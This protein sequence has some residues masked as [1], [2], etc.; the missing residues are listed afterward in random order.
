MGQ[1][2]F[3]F[4]YIYIAIPTTLLFLF[5]SEQS[6]ARGYEVDILRETFKY[7][8]QSKR[9]V[10]LQDIHQGCAKVNCI[11]SIDSPEFARV[12]EYNE[13]RN[14]DIMFV[15]T[16]RGETKIY[17]KQI[18]Q[19]H[20]VVNDKFNGE[21]VVMTYC[22]LCGSVVAFIPKIE[23]QYTHLGVSG[24]LHNSDLILYDKITYSLWQQ[25]TG[26]AIVG[27]QTGNR[28]PIISSGIGTWEEVQHSYPKAKVLKFPPGSRK[29][30]RK[31]LYGNYENTNKL[32]FP[33]SA[34]DARLAGKTF[35]YG[36][37]IEGRYLALEETYLKRKRFHVETFADR[38]IRVELEKGQVKAFEAKTQEEF[39]VIRLYW[40]AWF[41][42]HPTT[43]LRKT[44]L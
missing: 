27:P 16:Y 42:F 30:Y 19:L 21:P 43:E 40:F 38:V 15:L 34:T 20:E 37:E 2:N 8:A 17:P 3:S 32:M 5:I 11:Q 28:L 6:S 36:I 35:V 39:K 23:N 29:R 4:R 18:M 33:V 7:S 14:R 1:I 13:F 31:P 25:V 24:L 12:D 22:P 26:K 44:P 10:S 41:A 9:S